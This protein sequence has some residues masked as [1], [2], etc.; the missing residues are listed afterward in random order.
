MQTELLETGFHALDIVIGAIL[1][2]GLIRGAIRGLASELIRLLGLV[3]VVIGARAA[4]PFIAQG[5]LGRL[6]EDR[7]EGVGFLIALLAATIAVLLLRLALRK[8]LKLTF[9]GK[10]ERL[11]GAGIG[12]LVTAIFCAAGLVLAALGPWPTVR[13]TIRH[14][15]WAGQ[16]AHEWFP[17]MYEML[18]DRYHLPALPTDK[19]PT[20]EEGGALPRDPE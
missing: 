1:L 15:S 10:L 14:R 2:F 19:G 4:T 8:V 20:G 13:E 11:G 9:S 16:R 5:L 17:P 18:A 3:L 7:V 6:P 12:L